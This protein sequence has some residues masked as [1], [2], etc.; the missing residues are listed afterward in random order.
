MKN[1]LMYLAILGIWYPWNAT[2]QQRKPTNLAISHNKTTNI[3]FPFSIVGVDRGSPDILVQKAQGAAH[4]LQVKSSIA[5]FDTTNLSVITGDGRLHSFILSYAKS[6]KELEYVVPKIPSEQIPGSNANEEHLETNI[7]LLKLLP[8]D[9]LIKGRKAFGMECALQG[10]FVQDNLFY[11]VFQISNKSAI[12]Y[13]M[14]NLRFFVRDNKQVKRTASQELEISPIPIPKCNVSVA[15]SAKQKIVYVLPKFTLAD[16]KHLL[17]E[18]KEKD[19][20]RNFEIRLKNKDLMKAK[21]IN[22]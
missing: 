15:G 16:Q 9:K 8:S 2:A 4:I 6:P 10:L 20:G 21:W 3:V 13:D 7:R 12:D 17:V 19:G 22:D 11:F 1:I 18:I 14:E 5:D